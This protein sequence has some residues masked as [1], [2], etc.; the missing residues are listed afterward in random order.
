MKQCLILFAHDAPACS[1]DGFIR[2]SHNHTHHTILHN[3]WKESTLS[4][5]V[6]DSSPLR[7][8][9]YTVASC[10][11]RPSFIN[12]TLCHYQCYTVASCCNN[13]TLWHHVA[14]CHYQCYTVTSCCNRP[15]FTAL[16]WPVVIDRA[17]QVS[18]SKYLDIGRVK[19]QELAHLQNARNTGRRLPFGTTPRKA[20]AAITDTSDCVKRWCMQGSPFLISVEAEFL[21]AHCFFPWQSRH[22]R[23]SSIKLLPCILLIKKTCH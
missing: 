20:F 15:S 19:P 18:L 6:R 1:H 4:S 7:M 12:A 2:S 3:G 14:L 10:C 9:C 17:L 13:A 8:Q 22:S 11:D 5:A 21:P 16:F 23:S